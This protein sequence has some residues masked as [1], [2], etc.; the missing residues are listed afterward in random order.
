MEHSNSVGLS[1]SETACICDAEHVGEDRGPCVACAAGRYKVGNGTGVCVACGADTYT[2]VVP[3]TSA[4]MFVSCPAHTSSGEGSGY[5]TSCTCV[6]GYTAASDGLQCSACGVG[7]FKGAVGTAACETCPANSESGPGSALCLCSAGFTGNDGGL[8]TPCAVGE[9]KAAVGSGS[10][11]ACPLHTSSVGGSNEQ[12]DCTCVVGYTAASDG[13]VCSACDAGTYKATAGTEPCSM[14]PTGTSSARESND[15]TD[16]KCLAGYSGTSCTACMAGTFKSSSGTTA[17]QLCLSNSESASGSALCYCSVGFTGADGGP[18]VACS[19]CTSAVTFT[20]TLAITL[21]EFNTAKR[22]AYVAGVAQALSV[23]SSSVA[24][25][26]VTEQLSRRRLLAASVAVETQVTV[27]KAKAAGVAAAAT[28]ENLNRALA[29]S[30]ISF[31]AVSAPALAAAAPSGVNSIGVPSPGDTSASVR[32]PGDTTPTPAAESGSSTALIAGAAAGGALVLLVG[33]W[34]LW[35]CRRPRVDPTL[36]ADAS[37]WLQVSEEG[38]SFL[39]GKSAALGG[40]V[41]TGTFLEVMSV[42]SLDALLAGGEA[43]PFVGDVCKLLQK[44][45]KYVDDFHGAEEECRR[46]SVW[47]LAM[48]GSF[49]RLAK[50]G[51]K[52]NAEMKALLNAAGMAVKVTSK[53]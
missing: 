39:P 52:V 25:T 51:K 8:C 14:C 16:C 45:K 9:Y 19:D 3:A 12:T 49:S 43:V 37:S 48:M 32:P 10:C 42:A 30:G 47:S 2:V 53:H 38:N 50:E 36:L 31:A 44:L 7:T 28:S 33:A 6:D 41:L 1:S 24:I 17:C 34:A 40:C 5:I 11:T 13:D 22:A 18:C 23:A 27:S 29:S 15:L 4:S 46:L 21:S 20:G 35:R 26:S